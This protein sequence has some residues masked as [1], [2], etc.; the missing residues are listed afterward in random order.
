M[1][2]FRRFFAFAT[3]YLPACFVS[4]HRSVEQTQVV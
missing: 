3:G 4:Y 1:L 2:T